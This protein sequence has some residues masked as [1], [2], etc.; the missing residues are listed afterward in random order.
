MSKELLG[1]KEVRNRRQV[2][3]KGILNKLFKMNKADGDNEKRQKELKKS[4]KVHMKDLKEDSKTCIE[5][6]T[7][8]EKKSED[9]IRS[10]EYCKRHP[11][12]MEL[13]LKERE[14][15]SDDVVYEETE[16]PVKGVHQNIH[17]D[18][19]PIGI[20][21]VGILVR[22]TL[23][24]QVNEQRKSEREHDRRM[25]RDTIQVQ[26]SSGRGS[27]R[28]STRSDVNILS[29]IGVFDTGGYGDVKSAGQY[30]GEEW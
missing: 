16:K 19:I 2:K 13:A 25:A 20:F 12:A 1:F 15:K 10:V 22:H 30:N 28:T 11:S 23:S 9:L 21:I 17:E 18:A 24:I 8:L 7:K 27:E 26:A 4:V 6:N 29:T 3:K 14:V 5:E